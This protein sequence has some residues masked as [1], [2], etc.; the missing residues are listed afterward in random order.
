MSV[1]IVL[2]DQ[3]V[4]EVAVDGNVVIRLTPEQI[5]VIN[6][7]V[8]PPAVP[9]IGFALPP[10]VAGRSPIRVNMPWKNGA[11]RIIAD[12][13]D[14][15]VWAIAFTPEAY[16]TAR[17]AGAEWQQQPTK[18]TWAL[19]RN[20]DGAII[21]RGPPY[22]SISLGLVLIPGTPPPRSGKTQAEPGERYTLS[23]WNYQH[24]PPGAGRMFM[25]LYVQ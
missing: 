9:E 24:T 5:E 11:P 7:P 1:S 10:E 19:V 13:N 25:E 16:S 6:P 14:S 17:F 8:K 15:N 23:V 22:G 21:L 12:L 4:H 20:R 2:T 18:R 3:Q